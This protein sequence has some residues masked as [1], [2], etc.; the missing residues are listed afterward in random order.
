[1]G[2]LMGKTDTDVQ[3]TVSGY[4]YS[5]VSLDDLGATEYTIVKI[6]LD[7]SSSV[8]YFKDDLEKALT[9]CMESCKMSPRE[10]NILVSLETF[11]GMLD[12]IH[13]FVPLSEIDPADYKGSIY[14]DGSTALWDATLSALETVNQ[15]GE[16]LEKM[17]YLCNGI[18]FIITDG[19]ENDSTTATPKRIQKAIRDMRK[20]EVLESIRIVLIGI[21][22]ENE[23]RDYLE[24]FQKD[25]EIDQFIWVG[26]ASA[27]KLAKLASFVSQ[28][29][30]STSLSLGSG[31]GSQSLDITF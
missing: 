3:K 7:R 30:T 21:G 25:V 10:E 11:N 28:S 8:Y 6:A 18:I 5:S 2:K 17:D 1:M 14:P 15:Y 9:S 12:E 31:R 24:K 22:D 19:E 27:K 23:T 29:I 13:G 16:S 4:S 20:A 26:N